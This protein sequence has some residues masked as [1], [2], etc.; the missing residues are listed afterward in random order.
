MSGTSTARPNA[1]G[2]RIQPHS[3]EGKERHNERQRREGMKERE[4]LV[5]SQCAGAA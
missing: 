2:D 4:P 5:L 3:G 1:A